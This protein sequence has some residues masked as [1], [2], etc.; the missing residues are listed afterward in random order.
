MSQQCSFT[1]PNGERC[2]GTAQGAQGL[3]WSHDPKNAAERRRTASRGGRG[4][5]NTEARAVRKL[6]DELTDRVLEGDLEPKEAHAI[7]ALQNIKL[8]SIEV[9]RRLA[10]SDVLEDFDNLKSVLAKHGVLVAK[11]IRRFTQALAAS[12]GAD[13]RIPKD[14]VEFARKLG[15][16][17][18]P[19]QQ[20]A[21]RSDHPRMLLNCSRQSGKSRI[22]ATIA[23]HRALQVAGSL[24]LIIAPS[25][26]QAKET[27]T[28][29]A[30]AYNLLGERVPA[31][32]YRK[33][34]VS[35]GTAAGSRPC[36]VASGRSG[37]S[38]KLAS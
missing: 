27:F 32:S 7:V 9:E 23:A 37:A 20:R 38:P 5:A 13:A 12:M 31:D 28:Q 33:L 18:D 4:K 1:K 35:L 36:P 17:P 2:G 24:V 16:D 8:R 15:M 3:C 11:E 29:A 22:A 10:E 30:R 34:G 19:W 26:R 6:M 21:L 25:E 14:P